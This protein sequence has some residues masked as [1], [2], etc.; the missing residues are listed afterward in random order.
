MQDEG[1]MQTAYQPRPGDV[2]RKLAA[3]FRSAD[4]R[5]AAR[6]LLDHYAS[7]QGDSH[8]ERVQLAALFL[9]NGDL[10]RLQRELTSALVDYR[11][12]LAAAEY[13]SF[14]RLPVDIDTESDVYLTAIEQ[15][16]ARY[17]TWIDSQR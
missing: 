15:D 11:D 5:R 12:T 13:P 14:T 6:E 1:K 7:D 8:P 16:R 10:A 9:S 2:E 17:L 3:E 4:E